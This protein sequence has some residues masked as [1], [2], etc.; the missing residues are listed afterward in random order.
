MTTEQTVQAPPGQK[1]EIHYSA[2]AG[3]DYDESATKRK[4]WAAIRLLV[5]FCVVY[6]VAA[7]IV[8]P[9]F[10]HIANIQVF[11]IPLAFYTGVLVFVVGIIVTRMCLNQ[12]QKG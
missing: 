11:N 12:D 8:T 7:M 9:E 4:L 6:F 5:I 1:E 2:V 10:K 3:A